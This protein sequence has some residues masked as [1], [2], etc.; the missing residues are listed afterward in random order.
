MD[1]VSTDLFLT[2]DVARECDLTPAAIRAAA[3]TGR[4]EVAWRT[5]GGVRLFARDAIE[6]FRQDRLRRRHNAAA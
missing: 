5:A 1:T 4:L 2:S 6:R 3:D